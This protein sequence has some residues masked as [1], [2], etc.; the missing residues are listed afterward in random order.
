MKRIPILLFS[1]LLAVGVAQAQ[2]T[3]TAMGRVISSS[4]YNLVVQ[5]DSNM[6]LDLVMNSGTDKPANLKEG[7][8][9]SVTYRALDTGGYEALA[10]AEGSSL[11]PRTPTNVGAPGT[12]G[13]TGESRTTV[14]GTTGNYQSPAN[15]RQPTGTTGSNSMEPMTDSTDTDTMG[16]N[17][18]TEPMANDTMDHTT[19]TTTGMNGSTTDRTTAMGG[20]MASERTG[21]TG[22]DNYDST[23]PQTASAEPALLVI[24]LVALAAGA[25]LYRRRISA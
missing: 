3:Q 11:T 4:A 8:R 5:T 10:V 6:R 17:Q 14:V 1:L 25:F 2:D 20:T 16:R 21:A 15:P 23:L 13:Q 18:A 24:G 9:V 7:D 12:N 22:T 19:G